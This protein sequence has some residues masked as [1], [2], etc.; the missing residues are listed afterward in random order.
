MSDVRRHA[1][2]A[3]PF[4]GR[5]QIPLLTLAV[6]L[7]VAG[8]LRLRPE[9]VL[10]SFDDYLATASEL[11]E[12]GHYERA[13]DL[14]T[15]LLAEEQIPLAQDDRRRAHTLMA[16]VIHRFESHNVIH[17][18]QNAEQIL[19]HT[20]A[21]LV[22]GGQFDARMLKMRG[23]AESWLG[24][25]PEAVDSY[26][27]A[28]D[29]GWPNPWPV[30]QRV[31]EIE[32]YA[33]LASPDEMERQLTAFLTADDM[34][35]SLCFWALNEMVELLAGADRYDEAEALLNV[36]ADRWSDETARHHVAY[37]RSR[38]DYHL[39]RF[40]QAELSLRALR[41][42]LVPG[43][44]LYASTGWLLGRI[45]LAYEAPQP[46]L[47]FFDD[48]IERS[49]PGP[50]RTQSIQGRAEA[51]SGLHRYDESLAVFEEVIRLAGEDPAGSRIDL[52]VVRQSLTAWYE[53][54]RASGDLAA[55]MA[56]LRTASRLVPPGDAR[57][58]AIYAERRADLAFRM[59]QEAMARVDEGPSSDRP[60]HHEAAR[61]AFVESAEQYLALADWMRQDADIAESAIWRAVEAFDLAGQ[62][63]RRADVLVRF[64]RE[65]PES[66]RVPEALLR[67]GQTYQ[68]LGEHG[69][70]IEAY[71]R[72]LIDYP[73]TYWATQC[74][75]P[76]AEC[77]IDTERFD[78]AEQTLLRVVDRHPDERVAPVWP[79]A[80]EYKDALFKLGDLYV[81]QGV[82]EPDSR[83]YERAIARY[84]EAIVRYPEDPR[85]DRVVFLLADAYRRSAAR[86]LED[87]NDPRQVAFKDELA[88]EYL[89]RL[90]RAEELFGQ[91]IDRH[92]GTPSGPGS[93]LD[94]LSVK[95][96]HF[97]RADAIYE[98]SFVADPSD[99][100]PYVRALA[101]YTEAVWTY[102]R[103]P[104]AMTAYI[105]MINCHVR[106]GNVDEARKTL[107]R[108]S[109]A[110]G[111]I[112][113]EHFE[114]LPEAQ[115]RPFWEE[116]LAWLHRTPLFETDETGE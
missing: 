78:L 9:P 25:W 67:L 112:P 109:W 77:F 15:E 102:Q 1:S 44:P 69:A 105:Q 71:Q 28:L 38:V 73:R 8:L 94:E 87:L 43:D 92:A 82:R 30:R 55:A 42:R 98:K 110:L 75:V 22:A 26:R 107:Q 2:P 34:D 23:D 88:A 66:D 37:L 12:A 97:Y 13:S 18:R 29:A 64:I 101:R 56:Y 108:A 65:R 54:L 79:E 115:R 103:D 17:G 32:R 5:W 6:G 47:S 91:V 114:M 53:T 72:N 36:Q 11:T 113:D 76:L 95:L 68:A 57:V 74:L 106:M 99:D 70:A 89:R 40:E 96:A 16:E 33:G 19:H 52:Q 58:Q 46:A 50:Y 60:H 27:E 59:G 41:D 86:I 39:G 61:D 63:R 14:L 80:R 81:Q 111:G 4:V 24:R 100:G 83:A 104:M 90:Q 84:E 51:L 93:A 85:T 49:T 20:D 48:V 35:E 7:L 3:H 62:R 31:F 45:H 10:P 21:A 116:Y